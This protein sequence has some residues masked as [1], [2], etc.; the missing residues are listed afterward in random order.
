[1]TTPTLF[2]HPTI[3][4][5]DRARATVF[6]DAALAG[7][8]CFT[9]PVSVGYGPNPNREDLASK[10]VPDVPPRPGHRGFLPFRID[11]MRPTQVGLDVAP[12]TT[13]RRRPGGHHRGRVERI[14]A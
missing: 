5:A 2:G 13:P 8:R 4:V 11:E 9:G 12:P 14:G 3:G 7:A 1:M 10:L 6:Y